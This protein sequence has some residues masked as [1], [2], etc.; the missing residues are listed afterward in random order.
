LGNAIA[1]YDGD[2]MTRNSKTLK[3]KLR[4]IKLLVFDVDGVLTDN[5]VFI[6]DGKN[7]FKRFCIADGMA[8][9]IARRAGIETAFISGRYSVATSKRANELGIKDLYQKAEP[10][11]ISFEK[12]V[13]KHKL[14]ADQIAFMGDD[15]IDVPLMKM[16]GV[17]AT[18]PHAPE[19]VKAYADIVTKKQA[20]LGAAREFVD[21]ILMAKGLSPVELTFK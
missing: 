13:K 20:G 16:A 14:S 12:I 17:S 7:E 3:S 2:A 9:Y 19:Y 10:K 1:V 8:V 15:V 18:V 21:M 6:G 11:R 5:T 4:K